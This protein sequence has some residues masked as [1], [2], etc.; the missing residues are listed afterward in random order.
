MRS[1]VRSATPRHNPKS[2]VSY[3]K[4][5][6]GPVAARETEQRWTTCRLE[7]DL[8]FC[9]SLF[10][11]VFLFSIFLC[12]FVPTSVLLTLIFLT[13]LVCFLLSFCHSFYLF[14]YFCLSVCF[15]LFLS[16][17]CQ[18]QIQIK[19]ALLK[20]TKICCCLSSLQEIHIFLYYTDVVFDFL[21]AIQSNTL[22]YSL[23]Q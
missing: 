2:S 17:F 6:E 16:S 1:H 3:H 13:S 15:C 18:I 8:I 10:C 19:I 11:S 5:S 14:I 12:F 9:L 20:F 22:Q 7:L 23:I 21:I 4:M